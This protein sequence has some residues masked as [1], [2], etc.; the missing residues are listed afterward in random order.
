ML[1]GFVAAETVQDA[2]AHAACMVLPSRREGYGMVVIEAASYGTPS[3]VVAGDDNAAV[4][5]I[6]EGVN[7]YVAA[8]AAA[9][10][11]AAAIVKASRGGEALRR[12][13]ADWFEANA[14]RLSLG[15]LVDDGGAG[16]RGRRASPAPRMLSALVARQRPVSG[17]A[18]G[19]ARCLGA[20]R[21]TQSIL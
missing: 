9:E 14:R 19:E 18:P 1:P 8:S 6:D 4:E 3:V 5:H 10:D 7:G 21:L 20:S 13:T 11:L 12:S 17:G 16:L 15:P 2:I